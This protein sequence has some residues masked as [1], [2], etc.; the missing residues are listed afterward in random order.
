MRKKNVAQKLLVL[1]LAAAMTVTASTDVPASKVEAAPSQETQNMYRLYNP[2]TGEHLYTASLV[3]REHLLDED[4]DYEGIGWVAPKKSNTPVYRLFNRRTGDHH[5]TSSLIERNTCIR[6]GW[7]DEGI[8]WYS[9]DEKRVPVYRQYSPYVL[10]GAHNY[11]TSRLENDVLTTRQGWKAEG[12]GWYAV[13][14]GRADYSVPMEKNGSF[15]FFKYV[16]AERAAAVLQ[17]SNAISGYT[18]IGAA[19]DATSLKNMLQSLRFIDECN[20]LRAQHGLPAL[21]V[22]DYMMAVSQVQGN[23]SAY[24]MNHTQQYRVGENLAWGYSDPFTGWYT[25]E[26]KEYEGGNHVYHEIGHYLNIINPD[27]KVTGFS[28]NQYGRYSVTHEQSFSWDDSD[29]TYTVDEYKTRLLN[30]C[31]K[32]R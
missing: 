9:D 31:V 15:G 29:P 10:K 25:R 26:K 22:T 14:G 4:W 23:A 28:I 17:E 30:Y 18:H 2:G 24:T 20:S 21:K 5:Y 8:G 6:D 7:T 19:Q 12:I 32:A 3:E 11:T 1:G 16:G 27:S 13:E